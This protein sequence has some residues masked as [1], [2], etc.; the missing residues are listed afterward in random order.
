M[1]TCYDGN[2]TQ[3]EKIQKHARMHS[4]VTNAPMQNILMHTHTHAHTGTN[5]MLKQQAGACARHNRTQ[6]SVLQL[7]A[8][9][10]ALASARWFLNL[11]VCGGGDRG[12]S[13]RGLLISKNKVCFTYREIKTCVKCTYLCNV[14]ND[15]HECVSA[16]RLVQNFTCVHLTVIFRMLIILG[17]RVSLPNHHLRGKGSNLFLVREQKRYS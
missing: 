12:R 13:L 7:Q 15:I 6:A 10:F 3:R 1:L 8:I 4:Q 17:P 2:H 9:Q 5:L 11:K 16:V 14:I